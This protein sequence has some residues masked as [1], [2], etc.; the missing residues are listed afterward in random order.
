MLISAR[1]TE[2]GF[3]SHVCCWMSFGVSIGE[4]I[5]YQWTAIKS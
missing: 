3:S 2:A 5:A 4:S 1:L